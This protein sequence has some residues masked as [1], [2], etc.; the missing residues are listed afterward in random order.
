MVLKKAT[1]YG[2]VEIW[3]NERVRRACASSCADFI[4]GFLEVCTIGPALP[5]AEETLLCYIFVDSVTEAVQKDTALR[6]P[7]RREEGIGSYGG[8]KGNLHLPT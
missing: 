8:L 5:S 3:M 7:R 1:E 2:A 6:V 4:Y